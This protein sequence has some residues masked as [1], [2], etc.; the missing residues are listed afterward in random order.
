M[1]LQTEIGK[2]PLI[3][4]IFASRLEKLGV[5]TVNDLLF[6]LPFRYEDTSL[7]TAI[8]DIK[9]ESNEIYT[10][11]GEI[12]AIEKIYTRNGKRLIQAVIEDETGIADIIWFNQEY[13][14]NMLPIGTQVM[15]SGKVAGDSFF[16]PKF[17]SPS[18]EKKN[19][20][21]IHLGNLIGVYPETKG[22][23]SKWLRT[24][25][26][27]ILPHAAID[28]WLSE[29]I[30]EKY[31]LIDLKSALEQVHFPQDKNLAVTAKHRLAF[32]EM[33]LIQL[34]MEERRIKAKSGKATAI[35]SNSDDIS[36]FLS[37]LPFT[38]T[39][40]QLKAMQD[41]LEDLSDTTPMNRLIE[42]DV[43][44]G[45]TVVA[46]A[47]LFAA[48]KQGMKSAVMAPTTILAQQHYQ[49]ISALL[50]KLGVRQKDI[51]LITGKVKEKKIAKIYI[52]TQ[53]LLFQNDIMETLDLAIIDEQH[54]FGVSQRM[55]LTNKNGS[56]IHTLTMTAT[57][58]PRTLALS[59]YG[60]LDVSVIPHL[61][62]GRKPIMT[63]IVSDNKRED[64][65][66]FAKEQIAEGRQIFI[67]CPL[68]GL[69]DKLNVKSAIDE[70]ELLQKGVF[71]K[72]KM[73]LLHGQMKATEKDIL[74][75]SFKMKKF[76]I[77]VA[78]P[79]VEVGID[80]PN[81]TIMII[82]GAER[83]GL[84]Q[85]HQLRGR[86]GRGEY[87]SYCFLL[88]SNPQAEE[89]ERLQVFTRESS[90]LAIAEFDLK[91]RGPGEVYGVK[92]SGVPQLKAASFLDLD[93]IQETKVLA[94]KIIVEGISKHPTLE[95]KLREFHEAVHILN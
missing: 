57:P 20:A 7:L 92:Q 91:S 68:V 32:N 58:I 85:L 74:L 16:R 67:I 2:V 11:V 49:T 71:K 78:T 66:A 37:T 10:I 70:Y 31:N 38:L 77:L 12:L 48:Y 80:V 24:K 18:F 5:L 27:T 46:C 25:I 69:S 89:K 94:H 45:K 17:L 53:A 35:A 88:T 62:I 84:A 4:P 28:E 47:A 54:R 90:G 9:L 73:A 56:I 50:K 83:F 44:S 86:V 72:Y 64:L 41:V 51:S 29:S 93:L 39:N 55:H 87:A 65:Y 52:G 79:V 36:L 6:H 15:I 26:H 33:L 40:G 13:I 63:R 81:A 21:N 95:S 76:D 61:P 42:G 82:E 19:S 59:L 8:A 30:R 60:D 34:L 43:G 22:L 75:N 23:S 3:G 14:V 1:D